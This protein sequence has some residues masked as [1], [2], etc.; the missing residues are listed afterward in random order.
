[1]EARGILVIVGGRIGVV[2]IELLDLGIW[3]S[4]TLHFWREHGILLELEANE[5]VGE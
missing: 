2:R 4:V 1:M 5:E 3:S